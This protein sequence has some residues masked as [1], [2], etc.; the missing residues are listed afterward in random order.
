MLETW[1]PMQATFLSKPPP[2][3]NKTPGPDL[4]PGSA[5][6]KVDIFG[7]CRGGD[8]PHCRK[9]NLVLNDIE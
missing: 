1:T 9:F 5:N 7:L 3:I 2:S 8:L 4:Q 6:V